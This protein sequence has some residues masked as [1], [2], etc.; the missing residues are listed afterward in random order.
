MGL[1][2]GFRGG[3]RGQQKDIFLNIEPN[4]FAVIQFVDEE[5]S[6][7]I[8]VVSV[9]FDEAAN[10]YYRCI[11][12]NCP[13]CERNV[14]RA[15]RFYAEV[16]NVNENR[17]Q[18]LGGGERLRSQIIA[19]ADEL[20]EQGRS[21]TSTQL[22]I[23]RIGSRSN[24]TWQVIPSTTT[25]AVKT[26]KE[27]KVRDIVSNVIAEPEKKGGEQFDDILGID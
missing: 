1:R 24:T 13:Y 17:N 12:E 3:D 19:I 6:D 8:V 14:S 11:G 20:A 16:Y 2:D 15:V 23:K 27:F 22:K 10:R 25:K 26:K 9:H 7:D 21:L 4:S 5:D 18:I